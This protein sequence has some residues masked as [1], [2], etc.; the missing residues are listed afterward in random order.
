MVHFRCAAP[1]DP[2]RGDVFPKFITGRE[3]L[4]RLIGNMTLVELFRS[5]SDGTLQFYV[6]FFNIF[7]DLNVFVTY[8]HTFF[9][10]LGW[11]R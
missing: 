4:I 10:A 7:V 2:G 8:V 11:L 6:S 9:F 3:G 1:I 5:F